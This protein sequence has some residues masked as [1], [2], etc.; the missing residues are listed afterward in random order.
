MNKG[1]TQKQKTFFN[2]VLITAAVYFGLKYILPLFVPF[3]AAYFLAWLIRPA[4]GFLHRRLKVPPAVGGAAA[5]FLVFAAVGTGLFWLGRM[6]IDQLTAFFANLPEY[7]EVL[8]E[9]IEGLCSGCDRI[10]RLPAGTAE[11]AM[12]ENMRLVMENVQTEVIPVL[13]KQSLS[14]AIGAAGLL[15]ILL[16]VV[17]SALLIVKDMEVYRD[18]FRDSRFYREIHRVTDKLSKTGIAYLRTQGIIMLII[19]TICTVGL[20]LID[21]RYALLI[22]IGI[23]LFD[24]FPVLGSGLILIP[25]AV[26]RLLARD[27]RSAVILVV[28]YVIC[29]LV[30]EVLEPKMLGDKIG[31]PPLGTMM[32]MYVGIK[33]FGVSGF[34][35]GPVG[36][37]I[38]KTCFAEYGGDGAEGG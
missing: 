6:L 32:A 9:Q 17:V 33:L 25:W 14:V 10:F 30:R 7:Q 26:I 2:M 36:L 12:E 13:S 20:L 19:G 35:L 5:I 38:L 31:I 15:G 3:L 27:I 28:M 34:L 16:I 24:A 4:V 29:Q 18:K 11:A 8:S 37:I 1:F 23:A 21:N 22:G